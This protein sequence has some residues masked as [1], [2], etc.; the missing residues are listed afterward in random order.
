MPSPIAGREAAVVVHAATAAM[1]NGM[2]EVVVSLDDLDVV[3]ANG[4]EV[5]GYRGQ[6]LFIQFDIPWS[7]HAVEEPSEITRARN[8][9]N[10]LFL[11]LSPVIDVIAP[12]NLG[13]DEAVQAILEVP[14][15]CT[16]LGRWIDATGVSD[17]PRRRSLQRGQSVEKLRQSALE[18]RE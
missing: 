15:Q 8:C 7:E 13:G 3:D 2:E 9:A 18:V 11:A 10:G 12:I 1:A 4:P 5:T 14:P 17:D 6:S 16:D